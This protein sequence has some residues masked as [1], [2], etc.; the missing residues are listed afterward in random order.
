MTVNLPVSVLTLHQ[1][2]SADSGANAVLD[3]GTVH[4]INLSLSPADGTSAVY[5]LVPTRAAGWVGWVA[6]G[7][8]QVE[9][10]K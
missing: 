10:T 4:L 9:Q 5:F 1:S 7:S 3:C 2:I 8:W 6:V